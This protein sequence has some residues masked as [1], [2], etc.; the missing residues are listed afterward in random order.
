MKTCDDNGKI[1]HQN[2]NIKE[3]NE[4]FWLTYKVNLCSCYLAILRKKYVLYKH[5]SNK[6]NKCLSV[7]NFAILSVV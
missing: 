3:S 4:S 1:T 5:E 2:C 7:G 6:N